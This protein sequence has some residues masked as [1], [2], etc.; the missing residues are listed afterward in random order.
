MGKILKNNCLVIPKAIINDGAKMSVYMVVCICVSVVCL[1]MRLC[2]T[3]S[4]LGMYEWLSVY[5]YVY[6]AIWEHHLK[7]TVKSNFQN[8]ESRMILDRSLSQWHSAFLD[9]LNPWA[10]GLNLQHERERERERGEKER[11]REKGFN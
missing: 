6:V 1:R 11:K 4:W 2:V 8:T 9:L 3:Y 10:R 5:V 7:N